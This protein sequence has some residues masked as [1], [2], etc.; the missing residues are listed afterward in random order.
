MSREKEMIVREEEG[1]G[2]SSAM[3]GLRDYQVSLSK[4][5]ISTD[6]KGWIFIKD[7]MLLFKTKT[8]AHLLR[9]QAKI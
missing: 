3:A 5:F 9:L 8:K 7:F 2:T 6:C 4:L 1:V